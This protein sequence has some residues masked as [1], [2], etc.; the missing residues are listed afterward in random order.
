[1]PGR[2]FGSQLRRW[3]MAAGIKQVE[4]SDQMHVGQ[5]T[6]SKWESFGIEFDPEKFRA[7][8]RIFKL[9]AGTAQKAW[10]AANETSVSETGL[11]RVEAQMEQLRRELAKVREE[12]KPKPAQGRSRPK[13]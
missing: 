6:V 2:E 11:A 8:D 5:Q 1:M 10:I 13:A 9:A 12:L 4:L 3:R 7:F